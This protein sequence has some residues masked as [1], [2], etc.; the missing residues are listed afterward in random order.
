MSHANLPH[1]AT[2]WKNREIL[3][4]PRTLARAEEDACPLACQLYAGFERVVELYT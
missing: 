2:G 1:H 3:F 4:S